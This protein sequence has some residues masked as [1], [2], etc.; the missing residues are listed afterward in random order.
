MFTGV[1]MTTYRVFQKK[2]AQI[3]MHRNFATVI[4]SRGFHL[5]VQKLIVIKRIGEVWILPLNVFS[6]W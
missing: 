5:N 6:S 1:S 3:V 4:D 2:N